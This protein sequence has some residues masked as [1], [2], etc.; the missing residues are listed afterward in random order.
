MGIISQP[1]VDKPVEQLAQDTEFG[2]ISGAAITPSYPAATTFT[3]INRQASV[4]IGHCVPDSVPP[5]PVH[6]ALNPSTTISKKRTVEPN[7]SS[8]EKRPKIATDSN[9]PTSTKQPPIISTRTPASLRS[10][11]VTKP[12]NK[13]QDLVL[14]ENDDAIHLSTCIGQVSGH[15]R[16]SA[17]IQASTTTIQQLTPH[18]TG[19]STKFTTTHPSK[20]DHEHLNTEIDTS[21]FSWLVPLSSSQETMYKGA[22]GSENA[23]DPYPVAKP[24]SQTSLWNKENIHL[25]SAGAIHNTVASD[26]QIKLGHEY[27]DEDVTD[28][29]MAQLLA[30]PPESIKENHMPPSSVQG[31]DY[32]SRSAAEY[33]PTLKRSSPLNSQEIDARATNIAGNWQAEDLLDDDVD[34]N[35]VLANPNAIQEPSLADSLPK[36]EISKYVN[37]GTHTKRPGGARPHS[38]EAEPFAAFIRPSFPEKIRDRPSVPG[39]SSDTLLRA[40]FRTGA[41]I[42]QTVYSF[43]HQQDVLFE[44][45][46]RVTYSSREALSRKQ[47]FQFVDLFKDQQPYPA[48]TLTNW[49]IDSQLDKDSATFLDTSGGPR[50][51]WC[52]CKPVRD[53]KAAIGWTYAVLKIKEVNWEQILWAKRMICGDSDG[54]PTKTAAAKL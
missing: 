50:L 33:D 11:R 53:L 10:L 46:A 49:R 44:L 18:P 4:A 20:Y 5:G 23:L 34:W 30:E 47:H 6:T 28:E 39:M 25:D 15:R 29:D 42:S 26:E 27:L 2:T 37:V 45:Y 48:A 36:T 43:S 13:G 21:T 8:V 52:V 19:F 35:A 14:T 51:C 41:M 7:K 31:W 17:Q 22:A 12:I 38:D 54:L 32:E 9:H 40:C 3:P 1:Q 24:P 16:R